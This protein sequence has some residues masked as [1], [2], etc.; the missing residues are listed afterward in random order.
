[1]S[2]EYKSTG[3]LIDEMV[4]A[5]LKVIKSPKNK[6]ENER[7]WN[8]LSDAVG[9]RFQQSDIPI[10]D[11]RVVDL[12]QELSET[13]ELCWEAQEVV[14]RY[15]E[16]VE[17]DSFYDPDYFERCARGAVDAQKL[18]SKRNRLIRNI[19]ELLGES[20]YTQL[21]KSYDKGDK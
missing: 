13:L 14:M 7:R 20:N 18:N 12:W 21:E 10:W 11:E 17:D 16:Y 15:S 3:T 2:I 9:K 19:D 4:T 8:L 5:N 1:M 6:E